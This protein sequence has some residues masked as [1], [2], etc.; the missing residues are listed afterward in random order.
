MGG[1][2]AVAIEQKPQKVPRP[3]LPEGCEDQDDL[4]YEWSEVGGLG[5]CW[6]LGC[7]ACCAVLPVAVLARFAH[8]PLSP[9][10]SLWIVLT[11]AANII[12]VADGR[13]RQEPCFHDWHP[14]PPRQVHRIMQPLRR[15]H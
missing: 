11:P 7:A 12:V 5:H 3:E 10:I 13:V 8:S 1:E 15:C 6:L 14:R 2:R 4:C 9:D